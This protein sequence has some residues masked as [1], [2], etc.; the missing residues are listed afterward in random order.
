[1]V[2]GSFY[3]FGS[4]SGCPDN[5][6]HGTY[7]VSQLLISSQFFTLHL[8]PFLALHNEMNMKNEA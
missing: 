5:S 7:F 4:D 6:A 3:K 1:M 2:V 8:Y